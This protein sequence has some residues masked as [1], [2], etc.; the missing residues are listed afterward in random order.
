[1][2]E[3]SDGCFIQ[4][5][6]QALGKA[7]CS[8]FADAKLLL[9]SEIRLQYII[10]AW[11]HYFTTWGAFTGYVHAYTQSMP[12]TRTQTNMPQGRHHAIY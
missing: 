6:V 5:L 9:A 4:A 2:S 12:S 3:L 10:I 1:M 7:R 8:H 11:T